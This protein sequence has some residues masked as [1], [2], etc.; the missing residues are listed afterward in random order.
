M[1][2]PG[3]RREPAGRQGETHGRLPYGR[4]RGLMQACCERYRSA[5][6]PESAAV[7][8][9][10]VSENMQLCQGTTFMRRCYCQSVTEDRMHMDD[11]CDDTS[12]QQM[13]LLSLQH[14]S[15]IVKKGGARPATGLDSGRVETWFSRDCNMVR[16]CAV[17]RLMPHDR[18]HPHRCSLGVLKQRPLSGRAPWS[19]PWE[20]I[21]RAEASASMWDECVWQAGSARQGLPDA[22]R[23]G[24]CGGPCPRQC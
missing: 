13:L 4:A 11:G 18:E 7:M 12:N 21:G 10:R 20:D 19:T 9:I 5:C 3:L 15:Q 23:E 24:A 6:R 17:L 1:A 16:D 8:R 14:F 2:G 22:W